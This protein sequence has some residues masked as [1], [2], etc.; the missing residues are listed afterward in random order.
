MRC[1][2][3]AGLGLDDAS[4]DAELSLQAR[5]AALATQIRQ[6]AAHGDQPALDGLT[7]TSSAR[8]LGMD[9]LL[10]EAQAAADIARSELIARV[11]QAAYQDTASSFWRL[12]E[13]CFCMEGLVVIAAAGLSRC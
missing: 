10:S 8:G 3:A 6:A 2:Q 11:Q 7:A 9:A 5:K 1:T 13:V 4:A 12:L